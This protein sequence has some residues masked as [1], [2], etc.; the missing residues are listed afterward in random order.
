MG[1]AEFVAL[2]A[3]M[4]AMTALTIDGILPGMSDMGAQLG[5]SEDVALTISLFFIGLGIAQFF[6]GPIAD[7]FG[8]RPTIFLGCFIYLIGTALCLMAESMSAMIIGRIIQGVGAAG[9]RIAAK[10]IVRDR[11]KGRM[12]ARVMSF[13]SMIFILVPVFAPLVG[14]GIMLV[15]GWRG[16]FG[17]FALF[18]IVIT[19]WAALRMPETLEPEHRAPFRLRSIWRSFMTVLSNRASMAATLAMGSVFAGFL[20]FL[21]N[22]QMLM[23]ESYGLGEWF[24]LTFSAIAAVIGVTSILNAWLVMRLGMMFLSLVG[25]AVMIVASAVFWLAIQLGGEP[26]LSWVLMWLVPTIAMIGIVFG[27]L[28]A[29]AMEPL[30]NVAGVAAGIVAAIGSLCSALGGVVIA[31]FYLGSGESIAA[32]FVICGVLSFILLLV[33][34]RERR[35]E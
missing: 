26:D 27:N 11:F 23:G 29:L 3:L 2:I 15:T 32:G 24:P 5:N 22:A 14:Q 8:R 31:R 16:I 13:V 6:A 25:I 4:T 35:K 28:N 17:F 9:P 1:F 7:S 12:M 18:A 20:G 19:A 10:A 21:S 30:G 34:Q 33:A